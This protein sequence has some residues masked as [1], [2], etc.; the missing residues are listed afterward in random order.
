MMCTCSNGLKLKIIF[1]NILNCVMINNFIK[2][3]I[4]KKFS[5]IKSQSDIQHINVFKNN[6]EI[7]KC[8]MVNME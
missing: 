1:K 4:L 3:N 7:F 5:F 8:P 2:K 6:C